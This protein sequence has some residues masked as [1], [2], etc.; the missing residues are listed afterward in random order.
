VL[1]TTATANA[2][3][4]ADVAEQLAASGIGSTTAQ[5]VVTHRGPLARASLRLGV[6]DLPG[7]EDRLAWLATHLDALPGSGIIYTLTVSAA[8][9][10]ADLLTGAGHPV[11]SYTGRTDTAEREAAEQALRDNKVKALVAT[12]ALGMG[13]DKPDLG[14]VVHLGAPSSPVAYYQQGRAGRAGE[15][16]DVLL[17]PGSEDRGIWQYFATSS[18]PRADQAA[19]VLLALTEAARPLSSAALETVTDVRRTRLELRSRCWMLIWCATTVAGATGE[20]WVYDEQ[21]Y[22]RVA[23]TRATEASAMLD[24]QRT[25]GCRMRF[26]AQAL[27]DPAAADCGRC[28][29]CAGRWFPGDVP[30]AARVGARARLDRVGVPIAPRSQWPSGMARLEVRASGRIPATE[31]LEEGRAVARLTDLG[32][33]RRLTDRFASTASDASADGPLLAACVATLRDWPWER[34]PVAVATVPTRRRP[35]LVA[36]VAQYLAEVG[37]LSWL[38]PLEWGADRPD[39]PLG[40]PGGNSAFR[41]AGLWGAFA[42]PNPMSERLAALGRGPVLLVDDLIDS[43][44]TITVAGRELRRAGASAV[45]PFALATVA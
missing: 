2:R 1:A 37:K 39:G 17:L 43:R 30:E 9:D 4:V 23:A 42:V 36:S 24:Y 32:W 26:L 45:L 14:F 21:R 12:S 18:M 8:D 29:R 28:D 33:G 20:P 35:Q 25:P 38:G 15:R 19:A 13:F 6:L 27:D 7:P 5:D 11:R 10:A 34:R 41:L 44:W 22:A 31:R 16:A 3:V 40:E